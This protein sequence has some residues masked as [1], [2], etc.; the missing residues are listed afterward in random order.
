MKKYI[1]QMLAV[2]ALL[3]AFTTFAQAQSNY[4]QRYTITMTYE[5]AV[6]YIQDGGLAFGNQTGATASALYSQHATQ[7][8]DNQT[9]NYIYLDANEATQWVA[10]ANYEH[11]TNFVFNYVYSMT[12]NYSLAQ[13]L[14]HSFIVWSEIQEIVENYNIGSN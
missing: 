14:A 10:D 12:G 5:F 13:E 3:F 4:E 2:F 7:V 11:Y 1:N 6:Q 9:N 8:F